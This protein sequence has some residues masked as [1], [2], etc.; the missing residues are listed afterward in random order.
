MVYFSFSCFY[1]Y[2]Y[3][4]QRKACTLIGIFEF[5]CK[6]DAAKE[7]ISAVT[8]RFLREKQLVVLLATL[9][10]FLTHWFVLNTV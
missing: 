6:V 10:T 3:S 5:A 7:E 4:K 2:L 8:L 9:T 1:T